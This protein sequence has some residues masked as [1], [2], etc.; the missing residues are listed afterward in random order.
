MNTFVETENDSDGIKSHQ[1]V[2]R[3]KDNGIQFIVLYA[4]KCEW[5]RITAWDGFHSEW[6]WLI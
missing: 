1:P 5:N 6:Y 2:G 4:L 3:S